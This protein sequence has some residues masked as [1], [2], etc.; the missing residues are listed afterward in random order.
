[1]R[2]ILAASLLLAPMSLTAAAFPSTP[3]NDASALTQVRPASTGVT[4]PRIVYSPNIEIRASELTAGASSVSQV[5]LQLKLDDKGKEQ[6]VQVLKSLN[7]QIDARVLS[8]VRQFR[9][10]PATLD[11]QAI[12]FNLNLVVEVKQ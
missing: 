5:V 12:P 4:G 7:P 9:F 6:D 11:K 8:A 2:H 3:A 10:S 1:M